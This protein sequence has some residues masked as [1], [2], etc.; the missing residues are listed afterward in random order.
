M[1][2]S[3]LAYMLALPREDYLKEFFCV[4]SFLE[5]KHNTAV[6]FDTTGPGIDESLFLNYN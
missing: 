2:T 3:V 4:A 5:C 1:K 6:V